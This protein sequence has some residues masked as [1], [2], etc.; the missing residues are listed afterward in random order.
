[1][2]AYLRTWHRDGARKRIHHALHGRVRLQAERHPTV[3][4]A[5]LD[6][7]SVETTERGGPQGYDGAK[8]VSGRKRHLL[9]GT[10]VLVLT[11][12]CIEG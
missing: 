5:T 1:M 3:C 10:R 4:G 8:T 12:V 7:R 2:D 11:D 6:S 9:V